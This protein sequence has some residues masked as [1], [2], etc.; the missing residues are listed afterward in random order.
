MQTALLKSAPDDGAQPSLAVGKIGIL[1][2]AFAHLSAG[3][4]PAGPTAK[5]A[6]PRN[7]E[8]FN[9][10]NANQATSGARGDH[11]DVETA[12]SAPERAADT[13]ATTS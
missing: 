6:V 8:L 11:F 1:P 2:V 13:A 3:R 4:M 5:M 9:S 7:C 10:A 12:V